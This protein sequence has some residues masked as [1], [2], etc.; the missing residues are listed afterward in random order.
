MQKTLKGVSKRVLSGLLAVILVMTLFPTSFASAAY[1]DDYADMIKGNHVIDGLAYLGYDFEGLIKD[2]KLFQIW[3]GDAIKPYLTDVFYKNDCKASGKETVDAAAGDKTATGKVPKVDYFEQVG[4]N[5]GG[6]VTYY[7]FNYLVNV[8]GVDISKLSSQFSGA[9]DPAPWNTALKKMV[10]KGDATLEIDLENGQDSSDVPQ[11]VWNRLEPGAILIFR[12]YPADENPAEYDYAHIC[13]FAGNFPCKDKGTIPWMVHQSSSKGACLVPV[14]SIEG[15]NNGAGEKNNQELNLIYSLNVDNTYEPMGQIEVKKTGDAGVPLSGAVFSARNKATN[16]VFIIGPT[17]AQGCAVSDIMPLGDYEVTEVAA[18]TNYKLPTTKWTAKLTETVQLFTIEVKNDLAEGYISAQKSDEFNKPL[19]GVEFTIYSDAA[20]KKELGTMTTSELGVA[21]FGPLDCTKTYYVKETKVQHPDYKLDGTIYPVVVPADNTV[22]VNNGNAIVNYLKNGAVGIKKVTEGN[23]PMAGVVFGVYSDALATDLLAE[24][25]TDLNGVAMYG[26]NANGEYSIRCRQTLYFKELK[27]DSDYVL[28]ENI[29]PVSVNAETVTYANNGEAVVNYLK[30]GA[31]GVKKSDEDGHPIAN[32][33]FAVYADKA[34]TKSIGRFVTDANGVGI[35]GVDENGAY[36]LKCQQTVYIREVAPADN[37]WVYDDTVYPVKVNAEK[38]TFANNGSPIVN[39]KKQWQVTF[40]K[41]DSGNGGLTAGDASVV[42]AVYGLFN[43]DNQLLASYTVNSEGYFVTDKFDVGTGYYLKETAAPDGYVLDETIYSLDK[44]S[45]PTELNDALTT[46]QDVLDEDVV[47]GTVSLKKFTANRY[48]PDN[49]IVP[50]EGAEFQIYLKSAGSYDKAVLT[51]DTRTY[52]HGVAD[53]NGNIVWSNGTII[54]KE[55][56]Y[57]TFVV[58]QVSSWDNRIMVEDFDVVITDTNQHF[59]LSL[60]NPYYTAS[61]IVN[62]VDSETQLKITGGITAFKIMDLLTNEYVSYTDPDTRAVTTVFR[63]VDGTMTLPMELPYGEYRID[64]VTAPAGYMRNDAGMTFTIDA[65]SHGILTL[66]FYN[67]PLKTVIQIEKKGV[68]FVSVSEHE[69]NYGTMF[70]PTFELDYLADVTFDVVAAEDIYDGNGGLKYTKGTVVD[71]VVTTPSG[72]VCTKELFPGKYELVEK[73]APAGVIVN[74]DPIPVEIANNGNQEVSVEIVPL[75]NK[76]I[77]TGIA[78]LKHAYTWESCVNEETG[79]ISRNVILATGAEFT[80]GVYAAQEYTA[81]DG[82]VIAKDSLVAI[83]ATNEDGIATYTDQLPYGLYY[84]KELDT[85]NTHAYIKDDTSYEI[86]LRLENA[87]NGKVLYVVNNGD[88]IVNDFIKIE[89]T[90]K[91]TDFTTSAPVKG[92]LVSIKNEA[93]E[94]LYS[95]Y[96]DENGQLPGV[97]L[98]P[99]KYIFTEDLAPAGYI[100]EPSSFEFVVNEDGTIDGST[101]FTNAQT[102]VELFKVAADTKEYLANATVRV[103]NSA[104]EVVFEGVTD[105]NGKLVITG[106]LNTEETYTFAE[107]N[108]P[109]GYALNAE[110]YTFDVNADG[111]VTGNT[112]IENEKTRFAIHKVDKKGAVIAGAEFTMYDADGNVVD[113]Q[114]SDETGVAI[115]EGF[116]RG[117]F[118]I[119]E[120]KA[121]DGYLLSDEVITIVNDGTWDNY[122]EDAEYAVVN[123]AVEDNPGT[124]DEISAHMPIVFMMFAGA[125]FAMAYCLMFLR[126]KI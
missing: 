120:T 19:K 74:S 98:E 36:T 61:V 28:D 85:P 21:T 116:G 99:G 29:Y 121:P 119:K 68:Q 57:G 27:T 20:C 69:S 81:K 93:G 82:S 105:E 34:C 108:A 71:T 26:Y 100:R 33:T 8:A 94:T 25:T 95:V 91:K 37:T 90:I 107:V 41:V 38:V 126:K 12:Q 48:D 89:T 112:T 125:L 58:H 114:I 65:N 43:S 79:E 31:V 87:E 44:Y 75:E 117:E 124:G 17:D 118:T 73:S 9:W 42:G 122:S 78:L 50:E 24:V 123:E 40:S 15:A 32:V 56:A 92:A 101:T 97:V 113:V 83:V 18:P 64:E 46:Y 54:S 23:A 10:S 109:D 49:F 67:A 96:T 14:Y 80:F 63:T 47:T 115:F 13:I 104:G 103:M 52:D 76:F 30:N 70:A 66:D 53:E 6:F 72:P 3:T 7:Y 84:T 2:E 88:P 39:I 62:K 11:S 16:D 110:I 1:Q 4:L 55:L 86:D 35:Y 5:C 45:K 22:W 106:V 51:G 111:A 59:D 102:V 77:P 60:N